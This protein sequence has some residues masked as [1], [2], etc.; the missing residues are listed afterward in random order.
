MLNMESKATGC[1]EVF[2]CFRNVKQ[3]CATTTELERRAA[4]NLCEESASVATGEHPRTQVHGERIN[5]T[6]M[7]SILLSLAATPHTH[8][9]THHKKLLKRRVR[10]PR[11]KS[12]GVVDVF[13]EVSNPVISAE[14]QSH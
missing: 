13:D 2:Y 8:T 11:L 10:S 5:F 1:I 12:L 7:Y 6:L 3:Q 9:H 4:P 14:A